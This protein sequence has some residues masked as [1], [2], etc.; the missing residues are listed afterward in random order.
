MERK[1]TEDEKQRAVTWCFMIN[2]KKCLMDIY[3]APGKV[4]FHI[5]GNNLSRQNP[6]I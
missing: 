5:L 3:S 2:S 4:Y 1:E 6:L